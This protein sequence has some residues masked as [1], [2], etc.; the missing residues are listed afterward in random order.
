MAA[1]WIQTQQPYKQFTKPFL[2]KTNLS[3]TYS[4]KSNL[5][6]PK[7]TN[8]FK[9]INKSASSSQNHK[10]KAI[11][12]TLHKENTIQTIPNE[13]NQNPDEEKKMKKKRSLYRSLR[14]ARLRRAR[15]EDWRAS[16]LEEESMKMSGWITPASA[17]LERVFDD[18]RTILRIS[19]A[20]SIFVLRF[21]FV[22]FSDN[23]WIVWFCFHVV[24]VVNVVV[25]DV[26]VSG[27]GSCCGSTILSPSPISLTRLIMDILIMK[28]WKCVL[29]SRS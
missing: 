12:F 25:D 17:I 7:N 27:S 15:R 9:I 5:I 3:T 8:K 24:V 14:T 19:L 11:H 18:F 29:V 4:F 22:S 20:A 1:S 21:P 16:I 2:Q 10:F 13:E 28:A 23:V 6:I 26:V